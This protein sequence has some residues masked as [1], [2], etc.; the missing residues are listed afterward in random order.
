M[1]L[2]LIPHGANQ[3]RPHLIRRYG[4]IVLLLFVVG[5]QAGYNLT[6]SGSVLGVRAVISTDEL[7]AETNV[8]RKEAGVGVLQSNQQ[9]NEAAFM[10]AKDML[11]QQYWSHVA[12]DGTTP[13]QWLTKAGYNYASAGEN[14]AKNFSSSDATMAAWM[15]SPEHRENVLNPRYTEV[16]FAVA[17]GVLNGKNT[18]LIVA[19]YGQSASGMLAAA[20]QTTVSTQQTAIGPVAR[21][22][23][24]I[25]SMTPAALGSLFVLVTA[26]LVALL[27]HLYRDKLPKR[28]RQSWYRHHGMLKGAGMLSLVIVMIVLY[29]GGQI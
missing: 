6:T 3:Y 18:T 25:K 21:L 14:L 15:A 5:A 17:D 19:L 7:L 1:K 23:I 13:W 29:G 16:G 8:A 11:R 24:A 22:D 26:A 28:L 12:P 4:L 9:L 20:P 10:K 2:T 27:A